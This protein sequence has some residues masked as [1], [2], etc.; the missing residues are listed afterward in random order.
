MILAVIIRDL[1]LAYSKIGQ[2]FN[3]VIFFF[4]TV[5]VFALSFTKSQIIN[6]LSS[7]IAIIWFCLLFSIMLSVNNFLKDDYKDGTLEQILIKQNEFEFFIL[8]K[9][10]ANWL[11]YCLPL[12]LFIPLIMLILKINFDI[13]LNIIIIA[14]ISTL[15][16]NFIGCFCASLILANNKNESLLAILILPLIIPV[17]IFANSA[18]IDTHLNNFIDAIIFLGFIFSFIAPI[19]IFATSFAIKII[20]RN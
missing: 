9:L 2:L 7:Q 3:S 18:F 11:I 15:I 10:I 19:L 13:W 14:I 16:I 5:S 1:K 6:D 20:I 17:I 4:I 12:I 8:A